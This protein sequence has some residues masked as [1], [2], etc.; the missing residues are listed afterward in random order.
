ME[1]IMQY[2]AVL[3]DETGCEFGHTFYADSMDDALDYLD[4]QYPES[5]V[6]QLEAPQDSAARERAV[7][8]SLGGF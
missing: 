4:T 2:H 7:W 1:D 5:A 3:V 8:A 6:A